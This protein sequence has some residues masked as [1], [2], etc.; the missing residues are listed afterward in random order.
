LH[1]IASYIPN[2]KRVADIGGDHGYLLIECAKQGKLQK[3]IIGEVNPGPLEAAKK[4]VKNAGF[5]EMV[6]V[7]FG[8]GLAVLEKGE[9]DII[10]IAGMGGALITRILE[11][12]KEKLE[13]IERLI[14]QP[15]IGE[16][17]VRRWLRENHFAIMEEQIVLEQ[18]IYYE[19]IV[20]E[21][22]EKNKLPFS[23]PMW[24][25]IGPILWAKRDPLFLAKRSQ[26]QEQRL[27]ILANLE[28]A[29]TK[30]ARIRREELLEE[31]NRWEK[32]F[33]K[34]RLEENSSYKY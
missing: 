12:G 34:W 24:D 25:E 8:D 3:G 10:V 21:P 13:K 16:A 33:E 20:A 28:K 31:I 23:E 17:R 29:K 7:R 1:A 14:L 15:N 9:V 32:V 11:E 2:H 5:S 30:E 22:T 18:E 27:K 19:I 4:H 6:E 26:E